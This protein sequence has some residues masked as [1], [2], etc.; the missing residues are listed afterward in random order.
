[1]PKVTK[2]FIGAFALSLFFFSCTQ[3]NKEAGKIFIQVENLVEQNPDSALKLLESIEF[4]ENLNAKNY[5]DYLLLYIQSKDKAAMSIA[6]DSLIHIPV[7]YFVHKKD[8]PKIA[9]AYFYSGR[10]NYQQ[11]KN[12]NAAQDF[13][14]AKDYAQKT[15][16]NNLLGLI[17]YDLGILHEKEVNFELALNDYRQA[18]DYFLE[19]GNEKNAVLIL[20]YIGDVYLKQ[21]PPQTDL[22]FKNYSQ[23]LQY[24]EQHNDSSQL[25][26]TLKNIGVAYNL[27]KDYLHAKEF[28]LQSISTDKQGKYATTNYVILSRIYLSLNMPDSA[29][30]YA[31]KLS[32]DVVGNE[33]YAVI[34]NYYDLMGTINAGI[35]KYEQALECY[36]KRSDFLA[37]F[38]EKV[39]ENSVLDI[40]EKYESEKLKNVLQKMQLNRH[41]LFFIAFSGLLTAIALLCLLIIMKK[42]KNA[43]ILQ[44]EHNIATM[45]KML[46][47]QANND[48]QYSFKHILLEQLE[49]AKKIAQLS[50]TAKYK[51]ANE[52]YCQ[53]F[54]KNITEKL[55]WNNILYPAVNHLYKGFVGKLREK[56]PELSEKQVGLCCLL[57]ADFKTD[58]ITA[59]LG[60][61]NDIS[62]R[63]QKN[64][65][66]KIMG[67]S[68]LE[69]L[70]FS[71]KNI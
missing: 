9:L 46:E 65:L 34:Y 40:Q 69:K 71:L 52:A 6:E 4:P 28:L 36:Q 23:V 60:Y 50:N 43:K 10:V 61:S 64:R 14:S 11:K 48:D 25:I 63:T 62:T 51:N 32:P 16:N 66:R 12:K 15:E 20:R 2:H 8:I 57:I 21:E 41:F 13:L 53:V 27:I 49:I 33:N 58:E 67:F 1:M 19:A 22:A 29:I 42:R 18:H 44:A 59:I 26:P 30:Y 35:S 17:H 45:K 56:Y 47:K 39:M 24:L 7:S 38:Y 70:L 31:E 37:L 54:G 68:S 55:D 3:R 5:A